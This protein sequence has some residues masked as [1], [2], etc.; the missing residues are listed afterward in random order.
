MVSSE[1]SCKSEDF[2]KG[3]RVLMNQLFF[4]SIGVAFRMV[5]I[6]LVS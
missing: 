2:V 5:H 1:N 6:Y 3:E 4:L